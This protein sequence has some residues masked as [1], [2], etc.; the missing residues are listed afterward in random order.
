MDNIGQVPGVSEGSARRRRRARELFTDW[1]FNR[2][3]PEVKP[4]AVSPFV[5]R[6]T[7]NRRFSGDFTD[8][9]VKSPVGGLPTS[10]TNNRPL[11]GRLERQAPSR[12]SCGLIGEV[13]RRNLPQAK[14]R[15]NSINLSAEVGSCLQRC[16]VGVFVVMVTDV[17]DDDDDDDDESDGGCGNRNDGIYQK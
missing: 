11:P 14:A 17:T 4:S 6:N 3:T 16:L 15:P 2:K 10:V 5:A 9:D 12:R 8:F 7:D 1:L 13:Q